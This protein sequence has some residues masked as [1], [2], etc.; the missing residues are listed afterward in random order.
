MFKIFNSTA[1]NDPAAPLSS[2]LCSADLVRLWRPSDD[3]IVKA[4]ALIDVAVSIASVGLG[5]RDTATPF[6]ARSPVRIFW[7]AGGANP[8]GLLAS[9][10]RAIDGPILP[11]GYDHFAYVTTIMLDQYGNGNIQPL[12]VQGDEVF[13][14]DV[15][16][17]PRLLLD[18]SG[19]KYNKVSI[20]RPPV[21]SPGLV[22]LALDAV[23]P[24][25]ALR[26]FASSVEMWD[27]VAKTATWRTPPSGL[28]CA[29]NAGP[30]AGYRDQAAAFAANADLHVYWVWGPASGW[31]AVMSA[32]PPSAGPN[33]SALLNGTFTEFCYCSTAQSDNVPSTSPPLNGHVVNPIRLPMDGQETGL[34]PIFVGNAVPPEAL[35]FTLFNDGQISLN[36]L[37]T[38]AQSAFIQ[39]VVNDTATEKA[40]AFPTTSALR[41]G[42][43]ALGFGV[44][45]YTDQ[46]PNI[47]PGQNI[48]YK[49]VDIGGSA[50]IQHRFYSIQVRGYRVP[51]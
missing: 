14:E 31:D 12:V 49:W 40:Y 32:S 11:A 8:V 25:I 15:S 10:S 22:L 41:N 34:T 16:Y 9:T 27:P 46:F 20:T 21:A 48:Y 50:A 18:A 13:Y 30:Y 36:A 23:Y 35:R 45:D 38:A 3:D 51:S 4:T 5:G 1:R 6:P 29:I 47:D 2:L 37:N 33:L 17:Y 44:C 43:S 42:S 28:Q 26:L 39:K 19:S 24:D 7:V